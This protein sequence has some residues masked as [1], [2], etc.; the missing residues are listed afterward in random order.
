M[1]EVLNSMEGI[2]RYGYQGILRK[3]IPEWKG[4][5]TLIKDL[6]PSSKEK[7]FKFG[8]SGRGIS[9]F[10]NNLNLAQRQAVIR[11]ISANKLALI[12]GSPGVIPLIFNW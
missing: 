10:N 7:K 12:H 11:G 5:P 8:F 4:N 2:M 9:F 3:R 6:L 1:N